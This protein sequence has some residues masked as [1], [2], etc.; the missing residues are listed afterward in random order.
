MGIHSIAYNS[1]RRRNSR[2][3]KR[4]CSVTVGHLIGPRVDA[5][6]HKAGFRE[7]Q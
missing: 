6:G 1:E 3:P 7:A 4:D 2:V 5:L